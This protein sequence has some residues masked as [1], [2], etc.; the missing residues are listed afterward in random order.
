[1]IKIGIVG[2]MGRMGQTLVEAIISYPKCDFGGGTESGGSHWI[3][4][5]IAGTD[6]RVSDDAKALF[7]NTDVVLDFTVPVATCLH[8]DIAAATATPLII[9]TTGITDQGHAHID[10]CAKSTVIVQS[11][12]TSLGIN[13]LSAL[14]KQVSQRL[15]SNW[16]IEV[17]EMHHRH[18][19][20]APSGTALMLGEAAAE[21]RDVKLDDVACK[22]RDGND[23]ERKE[24]EIGFASL[25][26]GSVI[27]E[28]S[29]IFASESERIILSHHAENRGLF[30]EGALMAALWAVGKPH[31]RYS[32]QDVMGLL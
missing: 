23:S 26:G 31:G 22:G 6:Q 1:M 29:V 21:G 19:I 16:D 2:C 18:K 27:G 8:A 28:H 25:R 3:G 30:A 11:G 12:N 32:M 10:I 7:E 9:G 24:G 15:G 14:T 4:Q 13:L 20:D 17:L 5:E